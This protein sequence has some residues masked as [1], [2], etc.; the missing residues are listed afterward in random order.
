MKISLYRDLSLQLLTLNRSSR[1]HCRCVEEE[2]LSAVRG[3]GF[4]FVWDGRRHYYYYCP[5]AYTFSVDGGDNVL[6]IKKNKS[7]FKNLCSL[8]DFQTSRGF[9]GF[10]SVQKYTFPGNP[11]VLFFIEYDCDIPGG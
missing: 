8:H 10:L 2:G 6:G 3:G 9:M 11:A 7:D 1:P 5:L 4:S